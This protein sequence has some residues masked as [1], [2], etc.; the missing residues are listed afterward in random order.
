MNLGNIAT[1]LKMRDQE[2]LHH[3]S[4]NRLQVNKMLLLVR[5]GSE[6]KLI[7]QKLSSFVSF[8]A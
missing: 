2:I 3:W 5:G 4:Q 7:V 6:T 1:Q 8:I